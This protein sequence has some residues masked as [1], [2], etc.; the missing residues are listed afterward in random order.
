MNEKLTPAPHRWQKGIPSPNPAGRPLGG[1][2]RIAEKLLADL[3]ETWEEHGKA[4]LTRLVSEDPG[5]LAQIAFNLLPRDVFVKV[6]QTAPGN[7]DPE[8]W[9]TLRAVLDLIERCAPEGAEPAQIFGF[10]E[11]ALRAEYAKPVAPA[12]AAL[13]PPPPY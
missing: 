5:K 7:L 13:P 3:A 9:R 12:E 4:I 11:H 2:Q 8:S 10:I 1:R 6:E